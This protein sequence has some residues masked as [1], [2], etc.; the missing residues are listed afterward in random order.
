MI[1][2]RPLN[3]DR[4]NAILFK[5]MTYTG[6]EHRCGTTQR[7]VSTGTCVH[8]ARLLSAEKREARKVLRAQA[9]AEAASIT[10]ILDDIS[11]ETITAFM[12]ED[13]INYDHEAALDSAEHV[14][15]EMVDEELA[16]AD[17][18]SQSI[19]DIM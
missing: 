5:L 1:N 18:F 9:K 4:Q 7:Y 12:G 8:C 19:D 3:A 2:G 6:R 11:A 13:P 15:A 16:E 10:I 14:V 17:R